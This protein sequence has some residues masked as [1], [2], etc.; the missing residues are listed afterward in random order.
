MAGGDLDLMAGVDALAGI[1]LD[2]PGVGLDDL[3]GLIV[4]EPLC[5][6]PGTGEW[7]VPG[8]AWA[9]EMSSDKGVM[10]TVPKPS[11]VRL[12]SSSMLDLACF[13]SWSA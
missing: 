11:K 9:P 10:D 4:L 2:V 3:A 7:D 1:I 12:L 6:W 5:S 13:K 8:S